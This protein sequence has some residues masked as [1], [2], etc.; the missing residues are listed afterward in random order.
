MAGM[1]ESVVARAESVLTALESN[2]M[3]VPVQSVQKSAPRK[4]TIVSDE[5][6]PQLNL[7]G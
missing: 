5:L 3:S 7:F 1:P 6:P 2:E 4:K